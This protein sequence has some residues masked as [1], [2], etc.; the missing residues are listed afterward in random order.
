MDT[1]EKRVS[2]RETT[3]LILSVFIAGLC[4]LVYELLIGTASS[5]FLGD[6]VKQ[7]SITIG[8]YM[9]A[10]GAGSLLSRVIRRNLLSRFIAIEIG[11]GFIG[12]LSVPILYLCYAYTDA[13]TSCM[14]A[15]ILMIGVLIGLEIPLLT[16]I[17]ARYYTL[18]ANISNVLSVDYLGALTATLLFPFVLLP[19]W[20][21][22]RSSLFFGLVNMGIGFMNLWCFRHE[23]R[24][25]IKRLYLILSIVVSLFLGCMFYFSAHLLKSWSTILYQDRIIYTHQTKYQNLVL[26]KHKED[27]RLYIDGNLQFSAIDEYRYHEALIHPAF[28]LTSHRENVLILG[29]GDGLAAREVLKYPDISRIDLVDID[30]EMTRIASENRHLKRM[31]NDSLNHGKVHIHNQDAF[32]YLEGCQKVYDIIVADLPDPNTISLARM[33]SSEFYKLAAS[34]LSPTGVFVTQ[35]TSAFAS[36]KAFWCIADTIADTGLE[37]YPYHAYVPTFGDW[38]FVM[39]SKLLLS[40]EKLKITVPARFLSDDVIGRMFV[41]E[42]DTMVEQKSVSTLDRPLVLTYYLEGWKSAN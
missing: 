25:S 10:M 18:T 8:L 21:T 27:I 20:G 42:K 17:M 38:G 33:Y 28:S 24:I 19:F 11:L 2:H 5:Y 16:R 12:G 9:A 23:F 14:I 3:I 36:K 32:N 29:G 7:F 31:N 15:L 13:Y 37:V 35:A 34:K 39:A 41:F 22:F 30:P 40:P 6:S 26:T 4:S 1:S